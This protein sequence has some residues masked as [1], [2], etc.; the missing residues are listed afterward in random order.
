VSNQASARDRL[1]QQISSDIREQL[2]VYF[3]NR[4]TTP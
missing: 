2:A 1:M 3:S 4:R